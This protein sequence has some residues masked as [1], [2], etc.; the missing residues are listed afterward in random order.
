[1]FNKYL[2][3]EKEL[4]VTLD[5][6]EGSQNPEIYHAQRGVHPGQRW[7]IKTII[8]GSKILNDDTHPLFL[9]WHA[10][11]GRNPRLIRITNK[12]FDW[13]GNLIE[14][15]C[16]VWC[17]IKIDVDWTYS[18]LNGFEYEIVDYD[19]GIKKSAEKLKE[20]INADL[21]IRQIDQRPVSYDRLQEIAEFLRTFTAESRSQKNR[22]MLRVLENEQIQSQAVD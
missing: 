2:V 7:W 12:A 5:T 11:Q 13:N 3:Q 8:P 19:I 4:E 10:L 15:W 17:D 22:S 18:R 14:N 1:M 21:D 9:F 16:T 6:I 20:W